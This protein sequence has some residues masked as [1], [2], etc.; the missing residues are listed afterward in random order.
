LLLVANTVQ[1]WA[2]TVVSV[3]NHSTRQ[4][5]IPRELMGRVTTTVRAMFL[6]A[7]PIGA[8]IAGAATKAAGGDPRPAFL[9][10]GVLTAVTIGL[11]WL[12]ALRHY[13]MSLTKSRDRIDPAI[14]ASP[15]I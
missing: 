4:A 2:V 14:D 5:W 12:A 8:A 10:A 13:D 9:I 11:G 3:V 15:S 1:I 7:T 6:T